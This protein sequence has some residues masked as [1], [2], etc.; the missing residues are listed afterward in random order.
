MEVNNITAGCKISFI[1]EPEEYTVQACNDRFIICTF[2]KKFIVHYTI[3]DIELKVR[4]PHNFIFNRYDFTRKYFIERCLN[5]LSNEFSG[6]TLSKRKTL[7]LDIKTIT[8]PKE[9]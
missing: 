7:P 1:R 2:I 3:I 4:G 6:V 5:D 9:D 8:Q